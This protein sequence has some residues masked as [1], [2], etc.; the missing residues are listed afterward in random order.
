MLNASNG[1]SAVPAASSVFVACVPHVPFVKLQDRKL[2]PDFW[3]AYDALVAQFRAFDPELVIVFGADHYDALHL[4]LMP[5][6]LIGMEAEAMADTG[7][8]PGKLNVAS[9]LALACAEYLVEH[10]FDIATSYA[11]SVD[12]GFSNV[13]HNFLGAIDAR[14]IIPFHINALCHPRP[15]LRRCR[16]IGEAIGQFAAG[17]GK[18]VAILGS[19]GLSHETS[20]IFPQFDTAP[21]QTIRD[22]IVHGGTQGDITIDSWLG[23]IQAVMVELAGPVADGSHVTGKLNPDWDKRFLAAITGEDLTALDDWR[24]ADFIEEAGSGAGEIRQWIAA[25]AA[26][27]AAGAGVPTLDFYAHDT[28]IG[29]GAG[30]IHASSPQAGA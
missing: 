11:M 24:D 9:D 8:Y 17:L 13:L 2:L 23:D 5:S 3:H 27:R 14:P 20:M 29:V 30:M 21:N 12:H 19:G 26:A 22:F 28:P 15:T 18:R 6:V 16:Q 10:D 7:G 1:V 25:I 4:K